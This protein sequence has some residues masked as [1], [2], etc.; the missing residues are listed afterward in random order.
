MA[1][2]HMRV[3]I[4]ISGGGHRATAWAIGTLAALVET[5][6]NQ[7]VVSVASVSGGSIANG[8]VARAGDLKLHT[9]G[10]AFAAAMGP[11]LRVVA[12]DGLF[13][14][15]RAT[16]GYVASTLGLV[17]IFA[18]AGVG[19]LAALVAAG[20]EPRLIWYAALGLVVGA[21]IGWVLGGWMHVPRPLVVVV[22]AALGTIVAWGGAALTG[23]LHGSGLWVTL[24]MLGLAWL[25][26]GWLALEL[27]ARRGQA[28]E[29][30][31]AHG[32]LAHPTERRPMM[33]A[34]VESTVNHV[35]CATDL[36]SGDHFY[37]APRF[38]YGFRE[39][40][41]TTGPTSVSLAA[42]AQASAA[43]PGAF[44]PAVIATGP[45]VRDPSI[46]VPPTPPERVVL[47]DGGVYDN[48]ADQWESGLPRRLT[49]CAPLQEVQEPAQVLVV[50]NASATWEWMPF[51]ANGR[52]AHELV[53]LLRDQ[54]VQYDVS[55]ARRRNQLLE[56]FQ[57]NRRAGTG[58]VGV[59]VMIDR[60]PMSLAQPFTAGSDEIAAR[61]VEAVRFLDTCHTP[62]EWEAMAERNAHVA[63]TLGPIGVDTTLD[64]MEHAFTSTVVG[65]YVLHGMGSL[66]EFPRAVYAAELEGSR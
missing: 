36:E 12:T 61:A 28:V 21:A 1:E 33:L 45:F 48:M 11:T 31:L 47:S 6:T 39:G 19:L 27:L 43:L 55:T 26:L 34:E 24:A 18:I 15:G 57:R 50:S 10:R 66:V 29:R 38:L 8:A 4:A 52:I 65:L 41:S 14:P 9:D 51:V 17:G 3:G 53:G 2:V 5:G 59:I 22:G 7:E 30:A 42:A 40:I 13:F 58:P 46:D 20:R 62:D 63:T 16:R 23:G 64:L 49:I 60:L 35:F 37:M 56:R 32:L 25:V 54:G 44:P